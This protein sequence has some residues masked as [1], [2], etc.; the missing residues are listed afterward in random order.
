VPWP[1]LAAF[2]RPL[3]D[4]LVLLGCGLTVAAVLAA[5]LWNHLLARSAGPVERRVRCPVATVTML[6]FCALVAVV[7]REGA[8]RVELPEPLRRVAMLIGV[9]LM[10]LGAA[11]NLLGRFQ[12][13]DNWADQVT[14]YR[15]QTLVRTGVYALV[16]HPLYASLVWM[17]VG[18]CLVFRNPLAL[19]LVLA[20]FVP[21][22]VIRARRE[23]RLLEERFAEYVS[24]RR[25]VGMLVPR[26]RGRK[27]DVEGQAG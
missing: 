25:L 20:L 2:R 8:G 18:A 19:T 24:Y 5:V 9:G 21:A 11:V 14:L 16:R 10:F 1:D 23:E 12:L 26:W 15:R 3:F 17:L 27:H 7:L 13:S 4:Q 22:M 6:A